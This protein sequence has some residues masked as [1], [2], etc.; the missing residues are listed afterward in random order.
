M[1]DAAIRILKWAKGKDVRDIHYV[2]SSENP[3]TSFK[4]TFGPDAGKG[5]ADDIKSFYYL[6]SPTIGKVV[7]AAK[8]VKP[9]VMLKKN[10]LLG[11]IKGVREKA[12]ITV[13]KNGKILEIVKKSG[14]SVGYGDKLLLLELAR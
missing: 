5:S 6:S 7:Y 12:R 13:P 8:R 4:F 10:A 9:G 2:N 14:E 1:K 3:Q 11:H